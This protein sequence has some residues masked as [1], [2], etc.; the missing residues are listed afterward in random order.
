ML[1]I[2]ALNCQ[3]TSRLS[4]SSSASTA[5]TELEVYG[6]NNSEGSEILSQK[7]EG[8]KRAEEEVELGQGSM[9][10]EGFDEMD[11]LLHCSG[12]GGW[13]TSEEEEEP[14]LPQKPIDPTTAETL[15]LDMTEDS[16][17]KVY[18]NGTPTKEHKE[19]EVA[20]EDIE[21]GSEIEGEDD[22]RNKQRKKD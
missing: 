18:R 15:P 16:Q 19:E 13:E 2:I 22:K 21:G 5:P 11:E 4:S 6:H 14:S 10:D 1:G 12:L 8:E 3:G 17:W 9:E 7:H 20:P